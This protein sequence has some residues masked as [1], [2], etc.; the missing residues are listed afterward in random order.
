MKVVIFGAGKT[1][2]D[3]LL[4]IRNR[5]EVVA[6]IDN[7][8]NKHGKEIHGITIRSV[9]ELDELQYDVIYI[10]CVQNYMDIKNQLIELGISS[11]R[12]SLLPVEKQVNEKESK[13]IIN[14][15]HLFYETYN[16][17]VY[18]KKWSELKAQYEKV[19][20]YELRV[21]T[22][23]E[24]I[25]R[26]LLSM[27]YIKQDN[28]L[29]V[30][31][32][33]V[34]K[35]CRICNKYILDLYEREIYIVRESESAFWA[36]ILRKHL[37]DVDISEYY[38]FSERHEYPPFK[39]NIKKRTPRFRYDEI[40]SGK[41]F[42]EKINLDRP[43]A[44]ITARTSAYNMNTLGHDFTYGY[45]NMEFSAYETAIQYLKQQGIMTVRMGRTE[46][47]M[48]KIDNCIDYAGLYADDFMDLYL[49]SKCEFFVANTTGSLYMAFLFARPVLTVNRVPISFGCGGCPYEEN[50]L[51]IPKKYYD[52]NQ[53]K[54]LSLR[55]IIIV[56]S[57]CLIDGS[58]YEKK[59]IRFIDNTP[60]EI[61]E[62][63]KEM[64]ERLMGVWQETL[65]DKQNYEKYLEIYHEMET[66]AL[67]NPNNWIG[68]PEPTRISAVYLRGNSY[69]LE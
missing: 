68:G 29:H 30:F 22:I 13:N 64:V 3:F 26:F 11:N 6:F 37:E 42:F 34:E 14:S 44:C 45:R 58:L 54:Y 20:L 41:E 23:G 60:E 61:A 38:K 8:S 69:L 35:T 12:I 52:E 1:G 36:Y 32:P 18:E 28:N 4:T 10:A 21:D 17:D 27:E 2:T 25:L 19:I 57:E 15:L 16:K 59:G 63:V 65:E 47:L 49:S 66:A 7:D 53:K 9:K 55:E 33:E 46:S 5:E 56:E 24:T 67:N 50:S 48:D 43:Y 40:E 51:Y 39:V 31:V 62:A